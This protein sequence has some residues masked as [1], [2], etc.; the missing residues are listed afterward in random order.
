VEERRPH[1]GR[2]LVD[3]R[4]AVVQAPPEV[5]FEPIRRIGGRTGWY[6]GDALWRLRGSLDRAVGGVGLRRGRRDPLELQVGDALDFWRVESFEPPRLLRLRAEMR[7]P[8][9]AWLDFEVQ[10][11]PA[12]SL[13]RQTA[14]FEPSG[15]A[16]YAYWY[17]LLGL[18]HVVFG[19]MLRGLAH[20]AGGVDRMG[21]DSGKAR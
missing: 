19:G 12:G 3:V 5:T 15:I 17:G 6:Y 21:A 9:R 14:T 10:P 4:E 11:H 18:H 7:L 16:G 2:R 13:V 8:G 1:R 20:A